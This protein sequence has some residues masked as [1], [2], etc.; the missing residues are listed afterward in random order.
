MSIKI[1]VLTKKF[2]GGVTAL[3]NI[4]LGI[5][6]GIFGLLGQNGAGKTT[7][8]RILT[9]LLKPTNGNIEIFGIRVE[10]NNYD[11]I[12]K[13]IGYLPQELGLYPTMT[14][15]ESLDY[16]GG[17]Y[18][19]SYKERK[20][21]IDLLLEK[22]NMIEHQ[23]K[24]NKQLSGGMK[25]RVGLIQAMINSP[26]VLVVD[27]PTAGVD[28]EERIKIRSMLADFSK[29]RIILFSTHMIEDIGATCN[30]LC[31]LN[32][33]NVMFKGTTQELLG[34]SKGHSYSCILNNEQDLL[35]I[36]KEYYITS[37]IYTNSGINVRFISSMKPTIQCKRVEANL[38]DA[39]IYINNLNKDKIKNLSTY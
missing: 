37:K 26:K 11:E 24:K 22:T 14:V 13:I 32:K 7:L 15:R 17:L 10:K 1:K 9:T 34:K 6:E 18:G 35:K 21:R 38:E 19:L 25:R 23:R 2:K 5:D 33:G 30:Q 29:G 36:Q 31:I 8:M 20:K 39:Y 3:N 12:K 28:P 27:E 4:N 16:I